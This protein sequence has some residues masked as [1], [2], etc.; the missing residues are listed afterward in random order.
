MQTFF[1]YCEKL[2]MGIECTDRVQYCGCVE[3]R[4]IDVL[5]K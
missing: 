2:R 3:A 4:E 1:R 5:Q